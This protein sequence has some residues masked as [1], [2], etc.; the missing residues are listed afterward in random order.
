MLLIIHIIYVA[1][2]A[3]SPNTHTSTLQSYQSIDSLDLWDP[4][5]ARCS[6]DSKWAGNTSSSQIHDPCS[7]LRWRLPAGWVAEVPWGPSLVCRPL[8]TEQERRR[9]AG[10]SSPSPWTCSFGYPPCRGAFW[11]PISLWGDLQVVRERSWWLHK[12]F[13]KNQTL[14]VDRVLSACKTA[15]PIQYIIYIILYRPTLSRTVQRGR[16]RVDIEGGS[17]I[18]V[19]L[20]RTWLPSSPRR[21]P[22]VQQNLLREN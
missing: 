18:N 1:C 6:G 13:R 7:G 8:K 5:E 17:P 19:P 14:E 20:M 11:S 12:L 3:H 9:R 16:L 21:V 4:K 2:T 10:R 15:R 22:T